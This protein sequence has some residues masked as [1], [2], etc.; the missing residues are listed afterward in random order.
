M[1]LSSPIST[2][3]SGPNFTTD[4]HIRTLYSGQ[5]SYLYAFL[6]EEPSMRKKQTNLRKGMVASLPHYECDVTKAWP[7]DHMLEIDNFNFEEELQRKNVH[8]LCQSDSCN[9][10]SPGRC[11]DSNSTVMEMK[12]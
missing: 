9:L 4:K 7:L 11:H 5:P 1:P 3:T 12:T 8:G 2:W 10:S 6:V